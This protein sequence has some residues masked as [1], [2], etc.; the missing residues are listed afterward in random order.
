[1]YYLTGMF[2]GIWEIMFGRGGIFSF[3]LLNIFVIL[4]TGY[5]TYKTTK[6]YI[7]PIVFTLSLAS[8]IL[9][10][11][12]GNNVFNHNRFTSLLVALSVFFLLKGI[13]ENKK[14]MVFYGGLV[15]GFSFLARIANITLLSLSILFYF[16]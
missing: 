12:F 7:D 2:G 1:M 13:Y 9:L 10:S 4:T 3:R 11:K 16:I 14:W 8:L 5:I 6:I 15:I